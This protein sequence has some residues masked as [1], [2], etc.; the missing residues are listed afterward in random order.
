MSGAK[1]DD[2]HVLK[3]RSL[4]KDSQPLPSV[5]IGPE[6]RRMEEQRMREQR[7]MEEQW[8]MEQQRMRELRMRGWPLQMDTSRPITLLDAQ[9]Q[10]KVWRW[11]KVALA[12]ELSSPPR[13]AS[14]QALSP[15]CRT[16]SAEEKLYDY[17]ISW[18]DLSQEYADH[19]RK[20]AGKLEAINEGCNA[21]RAVGNTVSVVGGVVMVGAGIATLCSAGAA[22]PLLEVAGAYGLT[23][24]A[25]TYTS[26]GIEWFLERDIL[27][28]AKKISE[29]HKERG[30]KIQKCMQE[31]MQENMG[32]SG[33]PVG[34]D[35]MDPRLTLSKPWAPVRRDP[36]L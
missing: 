9:E 19:L 31:M 34:G 11:V 25:I 14:Q 13:P 33:P 6:M 8:R 36:A 23:G 28:D 22:A 7:R 32:G 17:I 20:S 30:E 3:P 2:S 35:Y 21:G 15:P 12:A 24:S 4:L 10:I 1:A 18:L 5:G 27:Q 29:E 26:K 16:M